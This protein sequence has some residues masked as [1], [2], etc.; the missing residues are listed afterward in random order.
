M[1]ES[2]TCGPVQYIYALDC[3]TSFLLKDAS[4]DSFNFQW[5]YPDLGSLEAYPISNAPHIIALFC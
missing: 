2:C 5:I 3:N 4:L 1:E